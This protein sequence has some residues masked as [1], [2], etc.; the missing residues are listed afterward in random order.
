MRVL[1]EMPARTRGREEKYPWAEWFDG[2][3]RLL[4]AGID[5]D[6]ERTDMRAVAYVAAKRHGVKIT[7]ATIDANIALQAFR[8][9]SD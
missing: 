8:P 6:T 2:Q 4:E 1:S 5:F 3:A 7:T 9:E